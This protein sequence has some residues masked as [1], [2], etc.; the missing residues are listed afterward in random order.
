MKGFF[1]IDCVC[2]CVRGC[3]CVP[4]HACVSLSKKK[5]DWDIN[6]DIAY[7]NRIGD[8]KKY[9]LCTHIIYITTPHINHKVAFAWTLFYVDIDASALLS[10]IG[11]PM[12]Q[13]R[14]AEVEFNRFK[15]LQYAGSDAFWNPRELWIGGTTNTA[16]MALLNQDLMTGTLLK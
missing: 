9:P 2:V 3:V 1:L 7:P 16:G 12:P 11:S 13:E 5:K 14:G 8:I 15:Q 10:I 4:M 6:K